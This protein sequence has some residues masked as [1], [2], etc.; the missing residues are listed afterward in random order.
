VP[1]GL[2][3]TVLAFTSRELA[4]VVAAAMKKTFEAGGTTA[5]SW[6]LEVDLMGA[7]VEP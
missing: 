7:R 4:P 2:G 1:L 6:A 5:R 3:P